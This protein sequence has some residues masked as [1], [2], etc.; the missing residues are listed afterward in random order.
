MAAEDVLTTSM[1]SCG[2]HSML[3]D[4]PSYPDFYA[5]IFDHTTGEETFVEHGEELD[6]IFCTD[7]D[8]STSISTTMTE[9]WTNFAKY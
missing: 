7:C 2:V 4:E 3:S 6:F 8:S 1:Y 9:H 5:Y